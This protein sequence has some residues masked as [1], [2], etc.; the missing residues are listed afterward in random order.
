MAKEKASSGEKMEKEKASTNAKIE[1]E[2]ASSNATA[3]IIDE[4][5]T[6]EHG[7]KVLHSALFQ[8]FGLKQSFEG[9]VH[10]VSVDNDMFSVK[11]EIMS[12]GN[13]K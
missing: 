11:K 12:E 6:E 4:Y 13:G 9:Y 2:K 5:D 1:K 7:L 10:T 8:N 3:D